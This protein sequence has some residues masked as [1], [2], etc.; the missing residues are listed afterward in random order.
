MR[1]S[2]KT[3]SSRIHLCTKAIASMLLRCQ[4]SPRQKDERHCHPGPY[5]MMQLELLTIPLAATPGLFLNWC[6]HRWDVAIIWIDLQKTQAQQGTKSHT[7]YLRHGK[8]CKSDY[9]M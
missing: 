6:N 8:K 1:M 4:W 7:P 2:V 3:H 9:D 5:L